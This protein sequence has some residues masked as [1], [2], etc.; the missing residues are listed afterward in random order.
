MKTIT[1][2]NQIHVFRV[3]IYWNGEIRVFA[4]KLTVE[5]TFEFGISANMMQIYLLPF[6]I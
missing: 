6:I 5:D 4:Y 1:P 2:V 3:L